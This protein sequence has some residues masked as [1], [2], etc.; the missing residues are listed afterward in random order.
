MTKTILTVFFS[1][2]RCIWRSK[3]NGFD[4]FCENPYFLA[5]ILDF[6]VIEKMLNIYTLYIGFEISATKLTRVYQE[7]IHMSKNKVG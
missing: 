6:C 5:A 2:T 7:I 1:E 4:A 3:C